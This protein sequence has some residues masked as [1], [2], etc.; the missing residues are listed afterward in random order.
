MITTSFSDRSPASQWLEALKKTKTADRQW[1]QAVGA[2]SAMGLRVVPALIEA[3][4]DE[5]PAVRHGAGKALQSVGPTI[6]PFMV[7][8]LKHDNSLVRVTAAIMLYGFAIDAQIAIPALID[9][10]HDSDAFVRQWAATALERLAHYF[11]PIVKLAVPKLAGL[12]QDQ[13]SVV[14]VWA[15]HALCS[16]GAAANSAVPALE[17]ALNDEDSWVR[18]A[19]AM[20]LQSIQKRREGG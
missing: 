20:A 1:K 4:G 5:H 9:S 18:E 14:R 7:K 15:A 6:V 3:T 16:I 10:L 13:D 17:R 12:M 19:A 8:A 11:G 2:L